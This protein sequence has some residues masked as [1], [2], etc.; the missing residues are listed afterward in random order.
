MK[1]LTQF[2]IL[3]S[4]LSLSH[5]AAEQFR[6]QKSQSQVRISDLAC[7][8]LALYFQG[9]NNHNFTAKIDTVTV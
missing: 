4:L 6:T 7:P 2:L 1:E 5:S 8:D 3:L 9:K